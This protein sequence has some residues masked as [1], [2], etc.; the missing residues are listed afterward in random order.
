MR[1]I[2]LIVI[3]CIMAIGMPNGFAVEPPLRILPLGD[4]LTYGVTTPSVQGGYRN[5]LH[6]LL[7]TANYNIDFVGTYSDDNNPALTDVNHQGLPGAQ[8]NEI[9]EYLPDW[10]SA[11]EDPDVVLL[12]IG[13]NDIWNY[14]PVSTVQT[15]LA[16]LIAD[17]ATLKP[18]AKIVVSSLPKRTDNVDFEAQQVLYNSG[19]PGIVAQQI[20]LGRQVSFMDIRPVLANDN[21]L[22]S[23][24][25]H[26]STTGYDKLA[27]AWASALAGVISPQGTSNPPVIARIEPLVDLTH[28]SVVFSKPVADDAASVANFSLSGGLTVSSAVLDAS[29][30]RTVTLTTSPHTPG[31][32]YSLSVSGVKDR[33]ALQTMIAPQSMANFSP[34]AITNG[35][36]ENSY[37][38]WTA[39]GNQDVK[40]DSPYDASEGDNLV[41][42]NDGD[43]TP[44]GILSQTF[45]TTP[46]QT[47]QL[48]FD[49]GVLSNNNNLQ[50]LRVIV[51]GTT[52]RVSDTTPIQRVGNAAVTWAPRSYDFTADSSATTLTFTDLSTTTASIDLLLDNVRVSAQDT[53]SLAVTSTPHAGANINISPNDTGGAGN[54]TAGLI[55]SYNSGTSV[56]VTAPAMHA[57][58][59]FVK[60][61]KHGVD[62]P[63]AGLSVILTMNSN[64]A[65]DAV[66]EANLP[67]VAL[68]QSVTL[69]E[70]ATVGI[71]LAATDPDGD[72]PAFT[73]VTS[74]AHGTLTGITPDLTYTPFPNYHGT[75][76]FTFKADDGLL[77]SAPA[78]VSITVNPLEEFAQWLGEA[79][80]GADP[81]A[82]SDGDSIS[83]AVEYVIGGSHQGQSDLGLLPTATL[84]TADPDGDM[85]NNDYLVFT[86]RRTRMAHEDPST[87]LAVEWSSNFSDPWTDVNETS[88]VITTIDTSLGLEIDLVKVHLPYSLSPGGILFSRLRIVIATP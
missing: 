64:Q 23:D 56:T 15:R 87:T 60:W 51:Q 72:I 34:S 85:E 19:I 21:D 33:T 17:I 32:V 67:P 82:D 43:S 28:I 55:R 73:V 59:N 58:R 3:A 68:A 88:G 80:Q 37:D 22:S 53:P 7:T 36:F 86:Y 63:G 70:D 44:N 79:G 10:L 35:S 9:Q 77:D 62:L 75:D 76:S 40:S 81:T 71:M 41:A 38:G 12:L 27:G 54:G 52:T 65:L 14:V 69:D 6:S 45:A 47:Y 66:Y 46:G 5:H 74:P 42:F 24:G 84:A 78:T 83:N 2:S 49:C 57:G 16:N 31:L 61:R 48:A 11:L 18:F 8:I 39:S 1:I 29:T 30:K 26:L 20:A 4:S 50:W 13:T 25:V